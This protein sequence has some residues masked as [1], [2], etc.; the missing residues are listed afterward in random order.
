VSRIHQVIA[1]AAPGDAVT[2]QAFAWR[3]L[4]RNWGHESVIVAEHVHEGLAAHVV[5]LDAA[6]DILERADA[7]TLHYAV[8]SRA[9]E[10]VLDSRAAIVLCYHN[11]TPPEL[12]RGYSPQLEALC[13]EARSRL[14]RF[15]GRCS[16]AIADSSFNARDLHEAGLEG[17]TVVPLVLNLPV[18]PALREERENG[19]VV[20]TVGRLAPNKRLEDVVESFA[21]YQRRRAPDAWL[22]VIGSDSEF[23][24]YRRD[25]EALADRLRAHRVLFTGR[26]SREERDAWYGRASAYVCLSVHEGFCAPLVE[27]LA[28]EVPVVA[29]AAGAVPET[30]GEAGLL[31]DGDD[32]SVVAEAVH[33][34]VSS[35]STRDRLIA[36]GRERV[37]ELAPESVAPRL[38][39]A[40][41][42]L[43]ERL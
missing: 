25:L 23:E 6:R 3:A 41:A 30:L 8:W 1:S 27:A 32:A 11:V 26:I 9:V 2:D 34:V 40:L 22:A 21:L 4:L 42:P 17:A 16:V 13:A 33:E 20:V 29:R 36:A 38:R 31:V 7:L 18:E 28:H 14:G 5:P 37:H 10:A 12:L 15:A 43:L 24:R 39:A 19:P 35:A